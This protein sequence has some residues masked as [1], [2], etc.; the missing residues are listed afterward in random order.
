MK[1]PEGVILIFNGN[2]GDIPAN[3][4]R[5]TALDGKF[6]K[7]WGNEVPN[8]AGGAATHTHSSPAH[9]HTLPAHT[10]TYT[11]S[12]VNP[13]SSSSD[14]GGLIEGTHYHT[15]TSGAV[16]GGTTSADAVTYGAASNNPPFHEVI[17]IEAEAG[18]VIFD[19]LIGLWGGFDSVVTVPSGWLNCNGDSSTPNLGNKYLRGAGTE[20][21]AG[22]TGGSTTNVHNIDHAHT[23]NTHGHGNS[24][25]GQGIMPGT[26]SQNGSFDS[27]N[28]IQETH[29]HTVSFNASTQ[30]IPDFSGDLTTSET[31]EPAHTKL[32]AIQRDTNGLKP[33]GLIGLWL[34]A[35]AS[36]PRGWVLC[37]GNNDTLDLRNRY[38][39]ITTN[40]AEIGDTGGANTHTHAAQS[41]QHT[42]GATH[43]HTGSVSAHAPNG[44]RSSAPQEKSSARQPNNHTLTSVETKAVQ[45]DAAN[46]TANSSS[47]EPEYRTVA[48][49]QFQKEI[50]GF[51]PASL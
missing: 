15:G 13:D 48:Y 22:T 23:A 28:W 10:H 20:A 2:H 41:H 45:Y 5:V 26:P 47:N 6:P 43:T 38:I 44:G 17:F 25:S 37:D 3:W 9:S 36:V 31:V 21:N 7:A 16:S 19:G 51:V 14:G 33:R 18:A 49:I 42:T 27:P 35:T 12:T 29:T 11:T 39:K 1:I 32:V 24:T 8:T 40:T 30:A 4:A 46:T 34:G 50:Y